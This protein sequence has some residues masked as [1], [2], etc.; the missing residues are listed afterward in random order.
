MRSFKSFIT[1]EV[2]KKDTVTFDIPLLIRVLEYI[3]EDVKSDIDLHKVVE[4]LISIRNKANPLTMDN[5]SEIVLNKS[6][7]N[8]DGAAGAV[9]GGSVGPTNVVGSGAI[10]GAGQPPGSKSGEPGVNMKKRRKSPVMGFYVRKK[11]NT[12]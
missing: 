4:N 7:M 9:G 2:D 3:R 10:A 1:E 6:K 11:L 5:Y 12:K 8:E